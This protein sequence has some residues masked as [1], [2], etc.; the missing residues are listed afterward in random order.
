M[1][2][3]PLRQFTPPIQA[4][5][6]VDEAEDMVLVPSVKQKCVNCKCDVWTSRTMFESPLGSMGTIVCLRCITELQEKG[7]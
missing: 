3:D 7:K 2:V 1:T 4:R 6:R 5:I